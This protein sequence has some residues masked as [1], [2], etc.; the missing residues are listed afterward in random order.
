MFEGWDVKG[1]FRSIWGGGR[2]DNLT[3]DVG[4]KQK[5]PGVGFAM[6]DMVLEEILRA[7]GKYP[8]LNANNTRVL[9]TVFSN[10][11]A[12]SSNKLANSLRESGANVEVYL[13]PGTKLDK[14]L[15]FADKKGIPFVVII[16]PEEAAA[17]TVTIKDLRSGSQKT[18][19][20]DKLPDEIY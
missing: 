6:G 7:N 10:E 19:A 13:D 11:L 17:G 3:E 14:Q 12:V 15:K 20:A 8:N 2:Y 16:G 5:I 4:G 9:V 1:E 18:V